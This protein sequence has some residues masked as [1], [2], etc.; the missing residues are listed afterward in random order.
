MKLIRNHF[1][2]QRWDLD[3]DTLSCCL[4]HSSFIDPIRVIYIIIS[5]GNIHENVAIHFFNK[6]LF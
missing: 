3:V 2:F 6:A 1:F 4:V 5:G